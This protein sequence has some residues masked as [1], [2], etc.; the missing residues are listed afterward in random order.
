[1][2]ENSFDSN[3]TVCMGLKICQSCCEVVRSDIT[4]QI[5]HQCGMSFCRTCN[6]VKS[7]GHFCFLQPIVSA[8]GAFT[9]TNVINKDNDVNGGKIRKYLY[10][11]HDFETR[12]SQLVLDVADEDKKIHV[13]NLCVAHKICSICFNERDFSIQCFMCGI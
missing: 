7:I 5:P 13:V 8:S 4:E 2:R 11:F 10:V 6:I 9:F 1:M 3:S 12:G